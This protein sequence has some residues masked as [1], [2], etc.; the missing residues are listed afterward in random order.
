MSNAKAA[1]G[2]FRAGRSACG[3]MAHRHALKETIEKKRT[4]NCK[5]HFQGRRANFSGYV[6]KHLTT[7]E[8]SPFATDKIMEGNMALIKCPECGK[9]ISDSIST[10]P[11]CGYVLKKKNKKAVLIIIVLVIAIAAGCFSYFYYFKPNSI[12]DQAKNLIERGKYS[13]ADVLLASVP[14]S[15]RKEWLLVQICIA[16]AKEAISS[17]NFSLAEEK[18]KSISSEA[19]PKEL[20][21]E[22]NKQKANALL[23]QGRY[24]EADQ[25]YASLIQ[26]EEIVELRKQLF[27]ESRVLQCALRTKDNLIFP[28]SM[29]ISEA[30]C[31]NGGT[32]KN[33]SLSTDEIQVNEYKQPTI[34]LHYR[35]K[36]RGGSVTD[37]FQRYI[38]DVNS[39]TYDQRVSVNSLTADK[40]PPSYVEYYDAEEQREYYAEQLE[41]SSM[42]LALMLNGWEMS[43]D[44]NQLQR[45]NLAL[46]GTTAKRVD[47]IPNN[48]IVPLPT[49]ESVQ[50]TPNPK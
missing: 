49:P 3:R 18:L 14:S 21:E 10:C 39:K 17:G 43:L 24:I 48:E 36:A 35:A 33:T 29:I 23:G 34:V 2:L 38:W 1:S 4:A 6:A 27:Y 40:T 41:I 16:D 11:N 20:L 15:Q 19:I 31:L 5:A 47:F 42:N 25:Y 37:G 8:V 9:E 50:V 26:T 7:N 13:E 45:V 30:I 46:Q 28:E 44:D 32:S 12:M 22:I